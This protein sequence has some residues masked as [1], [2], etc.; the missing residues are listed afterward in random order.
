MLTPSA[1]V[2]GDQCHRPLRVA[3]LAGCRP[4][5]R[6]TPDRAAT[7]LLHE[8]GFLASVPPA[9]RLAVIIT[10]VD[11]TTAQAVADLVAALEPRRS[12]PR[13]FSLATIASH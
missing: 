13:D 12:V 7:V 1:R 11:D 3:A 8:R 4:Y 10:K 9:S 6:L 2:I 5:E